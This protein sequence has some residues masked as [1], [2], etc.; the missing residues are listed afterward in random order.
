MGGSIGAL[1]V[2]ISVPPGNLIRSAAVFSVSGGDEVV[3]FF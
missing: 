3:D 1:A 2:L